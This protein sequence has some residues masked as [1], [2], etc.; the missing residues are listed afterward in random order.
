MTLSQ[1]KKIC[2]NYDNY[3]LHFR[4]DFNNSQQFTAMDILINRLETAEAEKDAAE[5]AYQE[6]V[7]V[8]V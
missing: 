5:A 4:K 7:E 1:I 8:E 6:L 2:E 3:S